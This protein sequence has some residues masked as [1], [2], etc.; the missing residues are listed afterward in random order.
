MQ[1]DYCLAEFDIEVDLPSSKSIHNRALVLDTLYDLGLEINYPS[2]SEDSLLMNKLL[3]SDSSILNCENAGTVFRFLT[4]Y[5][6]VGN[7]TV[8]LTGSDRML[9]RPIADLV[10]ALRSLGAEIEYMG[11]NGY[12]P[13][14]I[15]GGLKTGGHV[16]VNGNLSSQFIS[17]LILIGPKLH[18]GLQIELEGNISSDHISK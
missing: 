9:K 5:L 7:K 18:G 3:K 14:L 10:E 17:A 6:S 4:A 15:I 12:P 8:E 1:L 16:K 11:Q 13:L 2:E